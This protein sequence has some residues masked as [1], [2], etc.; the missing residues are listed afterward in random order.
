MNGHLKT[1]ARIC[2]V[3]LNLTVHV[4]R[5]TF[6]SEV[7][8]SNGMPIETFSSLLGRTSVRTTQIYAKLL[9]QKIGEDMQALRGRIEGKYTSDAGKAGMASVG[10]ATATAMA[11]AA[12]KAGA[13]GVGITAITATTMTG[14]PVRAAGGRTVASAMAAAGGRTASTA[15]KAGVGAAGTRAAAA[16]KAGAAGVGITAITATTVAGEPVRV[17]GS[18]TTSAAVRAGV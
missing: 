12:D 11:T 6:A 1:I 2:G 13:A 17:T 9:G 15:D 4:A 14:E 7:A 3:E 18:R 5:H 10:T 8:L 16:G